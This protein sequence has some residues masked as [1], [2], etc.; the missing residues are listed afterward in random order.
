MSPE[1]EVGTHVRRYTA[2][3]SC[4][5]VGIDTGEQQPEICSSTTSS[6]SAL[7]LGTPL[8]KEGTHTRHLFAGLLA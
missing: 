5:A 8:M 2:E 1:C 7:C 4:P 6:Q 3:V